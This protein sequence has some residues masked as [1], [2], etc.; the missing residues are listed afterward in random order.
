MATM[1]GQKPILVDDELVQFLYPVWD[2][3]SGSF[4]PYKSFSIQFALAQR[5]GFDA[6]R[7]GEQLHLIGEVP[8]SGMMN[9][10]RAGILRAIGPGLVFFEAEVDSAH[11]SG[12]LVPGRGNRFYSV[13][14]F[15]MANPPNSF[16]IAGDVEFREPRER[17]E[18]FPACLQWD[19]AGGRNGGSCYF[20]TH[21][22]DFMKPW[23]DRHLGV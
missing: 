4:G 14:S 11:M 10:H 19:I 5:F 7:A 9:E 17:C 16:R 21:R 2:G 23:I 3:E 22:W 20:R 15:G 8:R 13:K 12:L 1:H 6:G 18:D